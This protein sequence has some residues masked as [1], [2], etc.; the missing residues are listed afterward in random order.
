MIKVIEDSDRPV[1]VE[2]LRLFKQSGTH[3]FSLSGDGS[4][5]VVFAEQ[6]LMLMLMR[7]RRVGL[8]RMETL[9]Y[10]RHPQISL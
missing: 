3:S 5:S 8:L 2:S 4:F 7:L 6:G 1:D 9:L 10:G